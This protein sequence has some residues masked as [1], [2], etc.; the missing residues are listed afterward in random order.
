MAPSSENVQLQ[1][2][3]WLLF[4]LGPVRS[5]DMIYSALP[6][7]VPSFLFISEG[8]YLACFIE[9]GVIYKMWSHC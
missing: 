3:L 6:A 9:Q 1:S 8:I 7:F 2:Y 5:G 4:P